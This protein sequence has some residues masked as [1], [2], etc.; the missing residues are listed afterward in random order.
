MCLNLFLGPKSR[1]HQKAMAEPLA[2]PSLNFGQVLDFLTKELWEVTSRWHLS[3]RYLLLYPLNTN[4]M[5]KTGGRP[6]PGPGFVYLMAHHVP[7]T[8]LA[9]TVVNKALSHSIVGADL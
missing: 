6:T 2:R 9:R 8:P 3:V 7:L 5:G 1:G 4:C